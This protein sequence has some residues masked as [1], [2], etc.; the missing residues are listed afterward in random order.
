MPQHRV[1]EIGE[2]HAAGSAWIS[3]VDV[4]AD[5]TVTN[6]GHH[7]HRHAKENEQNA[8]DVTDQFVRRALSICW[9]DVAMAR[10]KGGGLAATTKRRRR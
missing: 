4:A 3:R 6:G 7:C 8:A 10:D 9:A 5:L 2:Q 1:A